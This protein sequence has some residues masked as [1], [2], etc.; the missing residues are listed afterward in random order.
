MLNTDALDVPP[1]SNDSFLWADFAEMRALIHPD[2][3]FSQTDLEGIAS[4]RKGMLEK[5]DDEFLE[6]NEQDVYRP[7]KRIF[8]VNQ[9]WKEIAD[10]VDRRQ[11]DFGKNYPFYLSQ[12]KDTIQLKKVN[13]RNS[14]NPYIA[15]LIASSLRLVN[16]KRWDEIT[17]AFEKFSLQIFTCLM[18]SGSEIRATWAH[19]GYEAVYKGTLYE[20]MLSIS[21]DIRAIPTF[22]LRDFKENNTGDGKIDLIAWH[23]MNDSR[24]NI[25]IAFAQCGCSKDEW[26]F[27]QLEASPSKLGSKVVVGHPW[28]TYYFLPL[29]LRWPDG[30][31]AYKFEIGQAI[32]VDR[33]R[34]LRFVSQYKLYR[35]LPEM[36]F[37]SEVIDFR[38]SS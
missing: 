19:G 34:L 25:P 8:N 32:M 37:V 29:D 33:L 5:N 7:T 36:P 26:V 18:P 30:D 15:L 6:N 35:K 10:S 21:R 38:Y 20:K 11:I 3:S 1:N 23:H 24:D 16:S 13:Y 4:R 17:G 28:A 22:Q 2:R 14:K 27:K 9:R 31:W 12:D